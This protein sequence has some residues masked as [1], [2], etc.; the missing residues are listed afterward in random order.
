[1]TFTI[2]VTYYRR[3]RGLEEKAEAS[4]NCER[5]TSDDEDFIAYNCEAPV[6]DTKQLGNIES[7][8]NFAFEGQNNVTMEISSF[9]NKTKDEIMTQTKQ[10]LPVVLLNNTRLEV[11]GLNFKLDGYKNRDFAGEPGN[12]V[13]S[14]DESRGDGELK[15]ATCSVIKKSD[16]EYTLNCECEDSI[17]APLNGA[18]GISS[19]GQTVMIYMAEGE[20]TTLNT[21]LNHQSL[22][23]RGSSSGLSG[24]AIAAIVI[25]LVVALIAIAVIVI[26]LMS[27]KSATAAAPFQESTLGINTNSISQ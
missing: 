5:A 22:Y 21:G 24:G 11:Y 18:N 8:N 20:E 26:A 23:E 19:T 3:L 6:D 12:V 1:M 27:R 10:V 9:A 14:F 17:S 15:N 13:M 7:Q 25:A 2:T 4:V 16:A